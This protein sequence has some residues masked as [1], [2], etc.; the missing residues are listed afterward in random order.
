MPQVCSQCS[1]EYDDQANFCVVDGNRLVPQRRVIDPMVGTTIDGRYVLERQIGRGSHGVVYRATHNEIPRAY[2]LKFLTEGGSN[3]TSAQLERFRREAHALASLRHPAIVQVIDY[4]IHS[5]FGPFLVMDL[6]QGY[7]L[8]EYLHRKAPLRPLDLFELVSQLTSGLEAAHQQGIVHRDLKSEN[9]MVLSSTDAT[10]MLR[11]CILDF[12]IVKLLE[13]DGS[14]HVP[15]AR[16]TVIGTPYTMAPEQIMGE[17]LDRRADIYALGVMLYEAVTGE[18]PFD[19]EQAWE[20]IESHLHDF[21]DPPSSR[22]KGQWIPA[23]L[24][25]LLLSMLAK[26]PLQ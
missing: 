8:D 12:G 17:A 2:A 15:A 23:N 22:S 7:G 24:D 19:G 21:P 20:Q 18:L 10:K 1:A 3:A 5:K 14:E 26:D 6:L 4:G 11:V 9:M 13:S 25:K 16:A